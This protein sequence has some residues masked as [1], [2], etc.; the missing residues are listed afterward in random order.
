MEKMKSNVKTLLSNVGRNVDKYSPQ[1]LLGVGIAG[2]IT[3]TVLAV[4]ATP[5]AM[6][7]IK[8]K[9]EEQKVEK[10]T[11]VETVKATWKCYIP[12]VVTG[13]LSI[14]CLVTSNSVHTRRTAALATAYEVSRTALREYKDKVVEV[15]GEKEA[16]KVSD[17][18]AKDKLQKNPVNETNIIM[19]GD[20]DVLCYDSLSGQYFKSN[21]DAIH[22]AENE[23]NYTLLNESYT[24]LNSFYDM[25]GI[26]NTKLG[27]ELG[28]NI[29]SGQLK[30]D[31]SSEIAENGQPCLVLEYDIS[32]KYD[33]WKMCY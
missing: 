8:E 21:I 7:N 29:D 22:K 26:R 10:L 14:A 31:I 2:M 19:T 18:V 9:K 12:T 33:Y 30:I 24:S 1:I 20:G 23:V 27:G 17:E 25:L 5:K 3:A 28:W 16:Q 15:V 4:K 13:S 11:T 6:E 32:P